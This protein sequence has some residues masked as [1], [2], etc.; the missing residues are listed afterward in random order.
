MRYITTGKRSQLQAEYQSQINKWCR[1]LDI[2]PPTVQVR[3]RGNGTYWKSRKMMRVPPECEQATLVH[4]L[5]HHLSLRRGHGPAFRVAL[6]QTATVAYGRA[7]L[8]PWQSEYENI[9]K[10]AM[11]HGLYNP[12]R[13]VQS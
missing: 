7:V 8:Y 2:T 10:W 9:K 12:E 5:A 6:V 13:K 4:E 3:Q 1:A 11:R